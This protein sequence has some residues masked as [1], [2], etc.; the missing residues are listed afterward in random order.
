MQETRNAPGKANLSRLNLVS[1]VNELTLG[2][3]RFTPDP[4]DPN[5]APWPWRHLINKAVDRVVTGLGIHGSPLS[6]VAL[7]PQPLPPKAQFAMMLGQEVIGQA[8]MMHQMANALNGN[9]EE[10]GIII[11]GGF[12]NRFVDDICPTPPVIKFPH[13]DWP[14]PPDPDPHPEWSGLELAII[15]TQFQ[16]EAR[17]LR[18]T[19]IQSVFYEAGEK[20]LH[21]ALSRMG[22]Y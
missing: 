9:G 10:R 4:D 16:N 14:F 1:L 15:G 6:R 3:S 21:V 12:I 22:G 18:N 17:T 8:A 7:N 5:P 20:L 13:L 11:V 2:S 19:D